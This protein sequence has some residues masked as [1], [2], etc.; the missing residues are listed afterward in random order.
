MDKLEFKIYNTSN[1]IPSQWNALPNNDLFLKT[2]FLKALECSCP[3]NI[4]P[5]YIG[6][7]KT[8]KLVG[9]SIV[10][11]VQMYLDD[12]FR[13]NKDSFITRKVKQIVS[14]IV[15]GNALVVGNLM[16]TGQHGLFFLEEELSYSSFL[17]VIDDAIIDLKKE[18]KEQY[19]KKIR[20]IAFKDYFEDDAIHNNQ[21]FFK[22]HNLYKVQVQPNMIFHIHEQW[23]TIEDYKKAFTKK[24]RQRFN[25]AKNKSKAIVK[26]ELDLETIRLNETKLYTLYKNVSDNARVNSFI[27]NEKH[28]SYLKEHLQD[29]LKLFGYFLN[30][31][32]IGFYTLIL[33]NN[34]LE[35]Y[36]LG[37]DKVLQ[38][39]HKIYLNMLFDM[40]QFGIDN[41]Y[42]TIVYAR[43]AMEIKSSIGAKPKTMHIYMKH[44][45]NF[46]A[47]TVLKFIVKYLNP[48]REWVER[49]PFKE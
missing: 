38:Q 21:D 33:N 43:T 36:F 42:K 24:Y 18:I 35:T 17:D 20:I 14:K 9:I 29:N 25:S 48:T 10:Q 3:K 13:N 27:L 34:M 39:K 6:V 32:L 45:N 41:K 15:R 19:K 31:E 4:T 8:K 47:N 37:Y 23:H 1:A 30:N 11:R 5:Y 28:F 16:H 46:I 49:H 22:K 7:F 40:A 12:A 2:E 44:T 26:R